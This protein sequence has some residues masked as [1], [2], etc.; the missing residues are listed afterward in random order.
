MASIRQRSESSWQITVSCGYDRNGKKI[1]KTKT[2][3]N[4]ENLTPKRWEKEI[5]RIAIEFE[6]A[7]SK[8][9]YLDANVSLSDFV[10]RWLLEY[11]A[12]QLEPKTIESYK[13]ELESKILPALGHLRL[14]KLTPVNILSFLNNLLEDGIRKDGKPGGYSDRT[15]RYQWQILSSILQTA[16]YW[17]VIPDNPCQRVKCPKNIRN[18]NDDFSDSK[19]KHFNEDQTIILLD[20]IKNQPLKYQVAV[21]IVIFA[22]LRKGELL[23]LTW[24]DID[25][26]NKVIR[27]NKAKSYIVGEDLHTKSTKTEG[28]NRIISVPDILIKLLKEYKIWQTGERAN[29]GDLWD[30][31]WDKTPWVLTTW[32]GKGMSY[33]TL[34]QWLLK[35]L[36]K[37]NRHINDDPSITDGEKESYML[38]VLS[39]HKLRHT[40]ASL[41]I[42]EKTDARTVASR[43]GHAQVSTTLNIYSHQLKSVDERAAEAIGNLLDR[44]TKDKGAKQ[45]A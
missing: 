40:N 9:L 10:E 20:I 32:N 34:T 4:E 43:L 33:G 44:G 42:G 1:V 38:P 13:S 31:E 41:L 3:K 15:I 6:T 11:A 16:V 18:E 21:N 25:F 14:G 2:I 27:I 45:H 22:G 5:E 29:A 35:L 30:K 8:G 28:S 37:H 17:Q 19:I 26:Q 39:F 23:G 7:V 12:K 24:N 36:R